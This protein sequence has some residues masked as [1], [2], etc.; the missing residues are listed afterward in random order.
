ML[1]DSVAEYV[2][3]DVSKALLDVGFHPSKKTVQVANDDSGIG[4]LVAHLRAAMPTLVVME[5]TGGYEE[6]VA[7]ALTAAGIPVAVVN[8]RQ[9][10]DFAKAIGR[11][12]KTDKI[13]AL[14]LGH[15]GE[16]AKLEPT[17]LADE[18][19]RELEDQIAR[20]RQ[21]VE[22]LTAEQNRLARAKNRV[23]KG[24]QSHVDWLKKRIKDADRDLG[25]LIKQSPAW[26]EREE[27]L[28]SVPGIGPVVSRTLI[29]ELP[30]LETL[31]RGQLTALVGLAPF[32]VDSGQM[33][34][35]RAIWG[36]RASVRVA[37]YQAALVGIRY[38]P[39]L[40]AMYTRLVVAGKPKKVAIVACARKLL[41]IVAAMVRSKKPWNVTV[42]AA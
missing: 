5:A 10:R 35:K 27:L 26:R 23:K 17:P 32:N 19:T 13:D 1:G 24:I 12:A 4:G 25:K 9:V 3:I 20:R 11:L 40:R 34:G 33:R 15:F 2:G 14:V 38:N 30:E 41:H 8:P 29:A 36:G 16:A 22:M 39:V 6:A 18:L 21:L 28:R 31:A 7:W 37:L 42:A